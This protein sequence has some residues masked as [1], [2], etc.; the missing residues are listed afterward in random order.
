MANELNIFLKTGLTVVADIVSGIS[1]ISQDVS[2]FE[3]GSTGHYYANMP[4]GI[5]AGNY[6]VIFKSASKIVG[7]GSIAWDGSSEIL[8]S[9]LSQGIVSEIER[10]AGL[11]KSAKDQAQIA[12]INTQS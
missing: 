10:P 12:A 2:L 6:L 8:I 1:V 5:A 3:R 7:S 11:L 4:S 9:E